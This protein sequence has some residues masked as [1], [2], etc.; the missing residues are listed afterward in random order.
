MDPQVKLLIDRK[1]AA[2]R[3][4]I[5]LRTLDALLATRQ[6][7]AKRVG[8]RVLIHTRD[9]EKFAAASHP[10]IEAVP[11]MGNPGGLED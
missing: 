9:L 8:R 10:H 7:P 4:S 5:S 11:V 1:E 3:L 6:L 2:A